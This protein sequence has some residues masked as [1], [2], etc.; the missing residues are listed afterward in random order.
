[1]I[2]LD[3][4]T[5]IFMATTV[6]FSIAFVIRGV[7]ISEYERLIDDIEMCAKSMCNACK[8]FTPNKQSEI[9]CRYCQLTQLLNIINRAK[10]EAGI[11]DIL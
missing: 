9:S 10:K 8:E 7:T 11:Y 2:D 1:M 6:A 5:V 4:I 3:L